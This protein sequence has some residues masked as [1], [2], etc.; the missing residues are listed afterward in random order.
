MHRRTP[1]LLLICAVAVI[2]GCSGSHQAR[3]RSN[4]RSQ[5]HHHK[6]VPHEKLDPKAEATATV[7]ARAFMSGVG[8]GEPHAVA[9]A[10]KV[11]AELVW[12]VRN[13]YTG[14]RRLFVVT[15]FH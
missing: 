12:R 11:A 5:V 8:S 7:F 6:K 1:L 2:T 3:S 13:D 10:R 14:F 4:R 15:N 9:V